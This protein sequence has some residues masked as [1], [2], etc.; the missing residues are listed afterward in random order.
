MKNTAH[1]LAKLHQGESP[2]MTADLPRHRDMW[3]LTGEINRNFPVTIESR[4]D[5]LNRLIWF[6]DRRA[7]EVCDT[8]A[9]R[10]FLQ[11]VGRSQ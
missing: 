10:L 11:Y 2:L 7:I 8:M 9:L 5:L 6:L 3:L 4:R 1:A